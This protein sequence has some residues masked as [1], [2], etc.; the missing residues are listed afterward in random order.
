[1][2]GGRGGGEREREREEKRIHQSLTGLGANA[3]DSKYDCH[4]R[5]L[6]RDAS[7]RQLADVLKTVQSGPVQQLKQDGAPPAPQHCPV[8]TLV[9]PCGWHASVAS[10]VG[11]PATLR[12]VAATALHQPIAKEEN[13]SRRNPQSVSVARSLLCERWMGGQGSGEGTYGLILATHRK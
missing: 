11:T 12:R 1:M 7:T 9:S 10:M 5:K 8:R 2:Q 4:S 6:F 3:G 13:H